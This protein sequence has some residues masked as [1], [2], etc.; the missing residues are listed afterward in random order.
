[1]CLIC[2]EF[3]KGKLTTKEAR[4]NMGEM[5][6]DRSHQ[7]EVKRTLDA[8]DEKAERDAADSAADKD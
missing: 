5:V 2:V 3:A 6:I 4:R 7:A 1:M 8:A